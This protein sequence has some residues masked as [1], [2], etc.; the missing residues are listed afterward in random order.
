MLKNIFYEI[1]R[2][3]PSF[4][5]VELLRSNMTPQKAGEMALRRIVP[6]Y[7]DFVGAVIVANVNGDYGAACH[8][9]DNFPFSVYTASGGNVMEQVKCFSIN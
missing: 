2:F 8:G 6:H 9:I 1:D 3:L 5:A 7:P 4:L